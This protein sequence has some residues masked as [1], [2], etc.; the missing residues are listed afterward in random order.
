MQ[1]PPSQPPSAPPPG[2]TPQNKQGVPVWVWIVV[3]VVG[4]CVILPFGLGAL[5]VFAFGKAV[6]DIAKEGGKQPT[7]AAA[8]ANAVPADWKQQTVGDFTISFPKDWS[9]VDPND[10]KFIDAVNKADTS[11]PQMAQMKQIMQMA[12][13]NKSYKLFLFHFPADKETAFA[14]NINVVSTAAPDGATLQ[15]FGEAGEAQAK[16][17]GNG[18]VSR[19]SA[20]LAGGDAEVIKWQ[21]PTTTTAGKVN[22]DLRTYMVLHNGTGY[23]VTVTFPTKLESSMDDAT[24]AIVKTFNFK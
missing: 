16:S 8:K 15:Q 5:G 2:Y 21:M 4:V 19:E 9:A 18:T 3:A 13:A 20:H 17:T 1:V 14:P 12:M 22:L 6:S 11:D 7:T 10:Q 24:A 23:V